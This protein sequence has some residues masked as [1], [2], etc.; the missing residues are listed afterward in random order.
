MRYRVGLPSE[1]WSVVSEWF[2]AG[3]TLPPNVQLDF[4][5]TLPKRGNQTRSREVS[6]R[7]TSFSVGATGPAAV[8]ISHSL[9]NRGRVRCLS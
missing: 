1:K 8:T 5:P 6:A 9:Q 2:L 7:R 3:V 4:L